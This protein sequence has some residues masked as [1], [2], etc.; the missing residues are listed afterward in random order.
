MTNSLTILLWPLGLAITVFMAHIY[1]YKVPK[2]IWSFLLSLYYR[3]VHFSGT[4][5]DDDIA[6]IVVANHAN[7]FIDPFALQIAINHPLVRTVRADW[8]RHWLIKWMIKIIGAVPLGR[9]TP[10]QTGAHNRS[11]FRALND[12]L[13]KGNWIVVFPEGISHNR[14]KLKPFKKGTAYIADQYIAETGK[15]VRILQLA[16]YYSDKSKLN[17]DIW[18]NIAGESI[19]TNEERI[20]D[21]EASSNQWQSNIQQAL[22]GQLRKQEKQQLNWVS[23]SVKALHPKEQTPLADKQRWWMNSQVNQLRNWLS[24]KKMDLSVVA[25]HSSVPSMLLRLVSESL[26]LITGLP[27]AVFGLVVHLPAAI[28]HYLLT[29]HQSEAEDK[30]ASNAFVI[31]IALYPL[32]WLLLCLPLTLPT[33]LLSIC[34]GAYSLF[35]WSSWNQRVRVISTAFNCLSEPGAQDLVLNM[36]KH[37]LTP[38]QPNEAVD[39]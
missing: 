9:A 1:A 33:L 3:D 34:S 14:S 36:A 29:R 27:I 6:T 23:E 31:G 8:L 39:A 38:L 19:Y 4:L 12:S 7:A 2:T 13:T 18:V 5:P 22:P 24:A 26:V 20:E 15:P 32:Y 11:S 30:W 16:L 21:K 17:S 35:Y 28:I 10:S 25:K 37:S